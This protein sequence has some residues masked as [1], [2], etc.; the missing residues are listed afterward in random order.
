MPPTSSAE[1]MLR[2]FHATLNVHGGLAPQAPTAD[3][4]DWVRDLRLRLL[5]EE[6]AELRE[7]MQAGDLVKIAD[8]LADIVYVTVGTA[9]PYGIPGS[10]RTAPTRSAAPMIM[11]PDSLSGANSPITAPMAAPALTMITRRRGRP[12]FREQHGASR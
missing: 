3:I 4:P 2:E 7:A 6:V 11:P 1:Q 8:G 10:R 9:V 5:D 12:T